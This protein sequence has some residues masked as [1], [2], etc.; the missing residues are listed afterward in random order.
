MAW[1]AY[2]IKLPKPTFRFRAISTFLMAA[3]IDDC[4]PMNTSLLEKDSLLISFWAVTRILLT[5]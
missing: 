5:V 3:S 1:A 2:V 4:Y